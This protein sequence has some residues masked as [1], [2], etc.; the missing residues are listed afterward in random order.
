[1]VGPPLN[2]MKG[3]QLPKLD[4]AATSSKSEVRGKRWVEVPALDI[5]ELSFPIIRVNLQE[6][7]PGKHYVDAALGDW[8]EERVRIRQKA[9]IALLQKSP[10]KKAQEVMSRNGSSRSGDFVVNPDSVMRD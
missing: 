2:L 7:G 10:D 5:F 1:M 3:L 4:I 9:D 6:F 8:I